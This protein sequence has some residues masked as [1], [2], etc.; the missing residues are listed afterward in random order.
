MGKIVNPTRGGTVVVAQAERATTFWRRAVGLLGHKRLPL[1][2]GLWLAP[3]GSVHTCGMRC[4]LDLLFLDRDG[5]VVRLVRSVRPWRMVV[6]G[7]SANSVIELATGWLP[8]D[9][10]ALGDQLVWTDG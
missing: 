5:R 2:A 3:C 10:V 1:G 6:G 8:P 4:A 9:A 7:R